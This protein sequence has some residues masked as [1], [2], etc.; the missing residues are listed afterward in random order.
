LE[1]GI[2]DEEGLPWKA[3]YE[4][5]LRGLLSMPSRPAVLNLQVFALLFKTM[6]MGGDLHLPIASQYDVPTISLQYPVVNK[7]IK[8]PKEGQRAWFNLEPAN[9]NGVDLRHIGKKAHEVMAALT[10]IYLDRLQCQIDAGYYDYEQLEV[11]ANRLMLPSV[12]EVDEIPRL[13]VSGKWDADKV[14]PDVR[15]MCYSTNSVKHK[16]IPSRSVG[17]R[18]WAWKEKNYIISDKPGSTITFP[19]TVSLGKL[20]VVYQRSPSYGF[21]VIRCWVDDDKH[22]SVELD[23]Y[24]THP[25]HIGGTTII[26]D[27]IPAGEHELNCELTDKTNDPNKGHEFRFISL[28]SI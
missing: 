21:G 15:P 20:Q 5:L 18:E 24:W 10:T 9:P 19:F 17:W 25:M 4:M 11:P 2:N 6:R 28:Q 1:V 14:V 16:L 7:I 26:R 13:M 8:N 27:D 3:T 23:G 22:R 12:E